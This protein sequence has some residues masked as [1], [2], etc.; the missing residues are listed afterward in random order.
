MC[1][2]ALGRG[3]F[4]GVG[5]EREAPVGRTDFGG[6]GGAWDE[7]DGVG[8]YVGRGGGELIGVAG[9]FAFGVGHGCCGCLRER[10]R[11]RR[12]G[13]DPGGS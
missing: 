13:E 4:V 11:E 12:F 2:F 5:R 3:H 1:G 6:G 10:E 8:V 7:E 9:G